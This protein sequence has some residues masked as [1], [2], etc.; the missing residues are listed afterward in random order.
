MDEGKVEKW[1]L[2]HLSKGKRGFKP[3]IDL[4]KVVLL[5]LKRMK[6]GFQWREL[7]IKEYF[8]Q[9]DV[10]WQNIYRYFNKWSKDGSFK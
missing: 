1:F 7:C 2:P 6:T 9:E 4:T 8:E 3:K 10:S 5:I